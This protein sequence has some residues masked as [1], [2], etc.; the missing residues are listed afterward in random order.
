MITAALPSLRD[1]LALL[2]GPRE[3]DGAPSWTIHDPAR[4]RYFRIGREVFEILSRWRET[5]AATLAREVATQTERPVA[6]AEVAGV[7]AFLTANELARGDAGGGRRLAARAQRRRQEWGRQLL[8][9]YL[10]WRVSLVRPDRFLSFTLPLVGWMAAPWFRWLTILIG[11]AG[12]LLVVR[13]WDAFVATLLDLLTFEGL[14]WYAAGLLAV[15]LVHELGH[16][17]AAKRRGVAVP[18]MGAAFILLW[19]VL[20]TDTSNAWHLTSRHDRLAISAAGIL[21]ELHVA[22]FATLAWSFLPDGPLRAAA[23]LLATTSWVTSLLVNLNP[24]MR[25]DGY[26]LL[27]DAIG[28]A[29]LQDR[30]FALGRWRLRQ[31]LFGFDE[32]PPEI[33]APATA[34]LLVA[35]GWATWVYRGLLFVGIAVL[36]YTFFFKVLGLFLFAVEIGWFIVRPLGAEARQIWRRR[37]RLAPN[38]N[39]LATVVFLA[40]AIALLAIP[41]RSTLVLPAVL[42]AADEAALYAPAAARIAAIHRPSGAVVLPGEPIFTLEAPDI[43]FGIERAQRRIETLERRLAR[44]SAS[45]EDRDRAQVL[46]GE[47][48]SATAEIH[49]LQI[50]RDRLILRAPIAGQVVDLAEGLRPGLWV[51]ERHALARVRG[52]GAAVVRAYV[53]E[54]DL[55]NLQLWQAATF[56]PDDPSTPPSGAKVIDIA[57]APL[58]VLD[59][60][61]VASTQ[62][63]DIAIVP[64]SDGVL[65]PHFPIYRILLSVSDTSTSQVMR[66]AVSIYVAP[67][68]LFTAAWN[69][70]TA[71]LIRESGF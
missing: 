16:A 40:G 61:A 39:L 43:D 11:T 45:V 13:Q 27:S 51:D 7:A 50:A 3:R 54:R 55:P 32:A 52:D 14:T 65:R 64:S 36:V 62:G 42:R 60:P 1:D 28:I 38:I 31:L 9:N 58:P 2:P 5:D 68:S 26:F 71:V 30:A 66:G 12:A 69:S 67:R 70:V 47:L 35:Y 63:G 20:Y 4:N 23:F 8:H 24:F 53:S 56:Y 21:A 48:A 29:N 41:W 17:Y 19:P 6:T 15:K 22:A 46:A 18:S 49:G 44:Q 34:R 37:R 59:E 33:C 25:F 10:F 57:P